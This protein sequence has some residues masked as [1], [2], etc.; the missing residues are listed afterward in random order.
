MRSD[1]PAQV[2]LKSGQVH[3][4]LTLVHY[5]LNLTHEFWDTLGGV[6]GQLFGDINGTGLGEKWTSAPGVY[7]RPLFGLTLHTLFRDSMGGV[8]DQLFG[9]NGT[10]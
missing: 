6:C 5:Q 10:G 1:K 8:G 9:I 7:T 4:G 3:Q 2:E